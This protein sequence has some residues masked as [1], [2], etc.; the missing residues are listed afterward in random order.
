MWT[1]EREVQAL[2]D[3]G[4]CKLQAAEMKNSISN[5]TESKLK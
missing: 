5:K 1:H 3:D 4:K 2:T